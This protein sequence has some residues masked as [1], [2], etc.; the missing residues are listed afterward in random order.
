[1]KSFFDQVRKSVWGPDLYQEL[2]AKP[3]SYSFSYFT[4]LGILL[5]LIG[6]IMPSLFLVP[7]TNKLLA[8]AP[9]VVLSTYP[10]ELEVTVTKGEVSANVPSPYFIP[11]PRAW[12]D[13]TSGY[14]HLLVID[15]DR[16]FSVEQFE[17]YRAVF[18]LTKNEIV[19][20]NTGGKFEIQKLNEVNGSIS[21][22]VISGWLSVIE[23]YFK[24]VAPGLVIALFF[25]ML[26]C[27]GSRLAALLFYAFFV[28]LYGVITKR[29]WKYR[30]AYVL[31]MHAYTLPFIVS[32]F[33]FGVGGSATLLL[34]V[35][36]M[37]VIIHYNLKSKQS[38]E[39]VPAT[40]SAL[41]EKDA[42]V[43]TETKKDHD[44]T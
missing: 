12:N 5:A 37:L 42:E 6:T 3:F 20:R 41:Q 2:L 43:N 38:S 4:K 9:N 1:M 11:I 13:G 26:F 8:E 19:S 40:A 34:T 21:E 44:I 22:Q 33:T 14:E 32:V 27:S 15:T 17:S 35:A 18:W 25:A 28:F 23:P 31:S 10:D 30:D 39:D 16:P 29:N 36:I 24:F 7:L